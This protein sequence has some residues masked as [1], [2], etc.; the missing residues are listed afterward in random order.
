MRPVSV[1]WVGATPEDGG[2]L[3]G[4][5]ARLRHEFGTE[6]L[7][8]SSPERPEGSWDPRRGQHSSSRILAWLA[9][10]VPAG[11]GRIL[12]LTDA[13]LFIPILTFVFGDAQM[14]GR[15]ALVSTAR[16]GVLDGGFPAQRGRLAL[17]LEKESVHELGHTYGLIHCRARQ[18]AM[19][20]SSSLLDVDTKGSGLCPDCRSLYREWA[21]NGDRDEQEEH[22]H[23]DRR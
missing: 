8:F 21:E 16:L 2:L 11:A 12:G 19:S 5:R 15:A 13:D 1:W 23:P 3:E 17:R 4:V 6:V 10:R 18:C 20:R 9:G 22:A 7:P 14:N